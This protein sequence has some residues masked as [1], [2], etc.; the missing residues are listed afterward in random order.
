MYSVL[1]TAV[2]A[3]C[4][5]PGT[6]VLV[7]A[8]TEDPTIE[9]IAIITDSPEQNNFDCDLPA[10]DLPIEDFQTH[11]MAANNIA[12]R[13][14]AARGY[15][16]GSGISCGCIRSSANYPWNW[17]CFLRHICHTQHK[18]HYDLP[19][20][21]ASSCPAYYTLYGIP[22]NYRRSYD[23][24]WRSPTYRPRNTASRG[25]FST[26]G[27]INQ[28]KAGD[29]NDELIPKPEVMVIPEQQSE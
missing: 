2:I 13:D 29:V 7:D 14:M 28:A 24:P 1:L 11:G 10:S 26:R 18:V 21:G 23:Y 12:A 22:Y 6:P 25:S 3:I 27:C 5:N 15:G 19:P 8:S 16:S 4:A 17:L 20:G 9:G